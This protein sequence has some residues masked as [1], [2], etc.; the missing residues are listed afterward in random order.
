MR[1]FVAGA[2]GVLGRRLVPE[3]VD[4]GHEVAG[5]VRDESGERAVKALGGEP[6]YGDVLDVESLLDAADG[7]DAIVHAATAIPTQQKPTAEDWQQN[8]RVRREGARNLVS[9]AESVGVDRFLLQ[10]VVWVARQPDGSPFDEASPAYPDRTTE[11]VLDAE[12][13]AQDAAASGDFDA[14]ILR[15]GWYYAPDAFHTRMLGKR[16]LEGNLPIIGSGLLGREDGTLSYLHVDDAARAFADA[17]EADATGLWH[18]VDD[19]PAPYAAFLRTL[20]ELLQVPQP[21]RMPGWLVQF[22]AGKDTIRLLTN[23]MPT[24]SDR[25][26]EAVGWEPLYPTCREGLAQVVETWRE[27]GTLV[28]SEDGFEWREEA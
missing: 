26:R 24:S 7:A 23:D 13:I 18:V 9:V 14:T 22:F 19:D 12:R 25:F 20:A 10:S 4:R 27:N 28:K 2:T 15:C 6:R 1:V 8:D 5:L 11:S 16:L 17:I 21:R 3:L